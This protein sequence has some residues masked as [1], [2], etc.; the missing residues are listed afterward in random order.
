MNLAFCPR[1]ELTVAV[2]EKRT[3]PSCGGSELHPHRQ[4]SV[5]AESAA[6]SNPYQ[7]PTYLPGKRHVEAPDTFELRWLLFSMSGRIPRRV[8]W[9]SS[10]AITVAFYL[11][12]VLAIQLPD[13]VAL[14]VLLGSY[15]LFLWIN[16]ALLVK[17][18]HDRDKSGF[19]VFISFIPVIGPVWQ[20]VE[21]G[22]LRGT[23]GENDY[24]RD[25]T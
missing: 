10:I 18:W 22:L 11:L 25:P 23:Y 6:A 7:A 14:F 1:C 4:S 16:L 3:C 9:L 2:T 20:F 5:P 13:E 8:F 12:L 24:G 21:T 19:W 15:A 17:R